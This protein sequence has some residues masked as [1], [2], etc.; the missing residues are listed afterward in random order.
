M[1]NE[2]FKKMME[3]T[4]ATVI[5]ISNLKGGDYAGHEQAENEHANFDRLSKELQIPPEKVLMVYLTKHLDSIK[6]WV[7]R[8]DTEYTPSEPMDGRFVDAI[9][10][11]LLLQGM[12]HRR[13]S[14]ELWKNLSGP[15][16]P[17]GQA[18]HPSA[19]FFPGRYGK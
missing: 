17:E 4:F 1:R 10:Y 14:G 16:L 11:L 7:N 6:T 19:E 8:L 18:I 12:H 2:E 3:H 5:E 15:K 9:L 13:R